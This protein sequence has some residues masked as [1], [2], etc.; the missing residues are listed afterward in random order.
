M[1]NGKTYRAYIYGNYA[2][3]LHQNLITGNLCKERKM[4]YEYFKK[5]YLPY[6][7]NDKKCKIL[8]L[9]C[10]LGNYLYAV[11]KCGY[12]NVVGVDSSKSVVEFCKERGMQ[13]VQ[14]DARKYLEKYEDTYDVILFN[15][16]IEHFTKD[17]LFEVLHLLYKSLTKKGRIFIKTMNLSNPITGMAGRYLDL[18]HEIGFTEISMRQTLLAA[19]FKRVKV[20]G[21]DIYVNSILF[22]RVL[23]MLSRV[24]NFIWYAINCL[25]GRT[26]V[27]IFEKNIIAIAYKE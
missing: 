16:V 23:K 24:N 26:T 7:P 6:F 11:K 15:D 9:G 14:A 13:C 27:K 22:A 5:N 21:A 10:G 19:S 2:D 12:K 20:I 17:E 8:D 4:I 18:T 1:E 3:N 25:Y